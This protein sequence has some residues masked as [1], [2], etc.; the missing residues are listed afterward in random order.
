M[1]ALYLTFINLYVNINSYQ[2]YDAMK[3]LIVLSVFCSL[4]T[5]VPAIAQAHKPVSS[6][7]G[8]RT[9][10]CYSLVYDDPYTNSFHYAGNYKGPKKKC[11]RASLKP[12]VGIRIKTTNHQHPL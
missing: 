7:Y 12:R 10:S 5:L 8:K 6:E 1:F 9:R 4:L 11:F 3:K 2:F